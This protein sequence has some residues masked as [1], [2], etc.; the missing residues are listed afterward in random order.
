MRIKM[1][2]YMQGEGVSAVLV[3]TGNTVNIL[4]PDEVY[5]VSANLGAELLTHRKA[6]EVNESKAAK[7]KPHYGAQSEPE[8][9][10]DEELYKAQTEPE[11]DPV[12]TSRRGKRAKG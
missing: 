2:E 12:M 11:P 10:N 5:E 8:L 9:R 4:T 6:V 3:R 7:A 1:L